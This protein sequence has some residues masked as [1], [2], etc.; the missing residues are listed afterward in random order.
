M[1]GPAPANTDTSAPELNARP[2]PLTRTT[3]TSGR[4]SNQHAASAIS[5]SVSVLRGFS[6]SGRFRVIAPRAPAA[7]TSIVVKDMRHL[8]AGLFMRARSESED[9]SEEH[10]SELQS[11]RH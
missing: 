9:R 5:R 8:S 6:L 10:T 11:L 1:P 2:L 4:W 7:F 3:L